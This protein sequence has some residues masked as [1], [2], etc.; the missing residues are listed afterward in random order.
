MQGDTALPQGLPCPEHHGSSL[1][2]SSSGRCESGLF[3]HQQ[4]NLQ[5]MLLENRPVEPTSRDEEK[6]PF[7]LTRGEKAVTE[8]SGEKEEQAIQ[9]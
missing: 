7:P 5:E 1:S 6:K 3:N 2:L 8:K 9:G 4:A